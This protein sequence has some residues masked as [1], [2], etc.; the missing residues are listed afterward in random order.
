[1]KKHILYLFLTIC[2]ATLIIAQE[3]DFINE[4]ITSY[5]KDIPI[6]LDTIFL[7]KNFIAL[8]KNHMKIEYLNKNSF[9][10]WWNDLRKN[11]PPIELFLKNFSLDHLKLEILKSQNDSL[12]NFKALN[13]YFHSSN[14][15]FIKTHP[16]NTYLSIS[17]PLFNP[18]KDWCII[19]KSSY[20]PFFNAGGGGML[21]IFV[22]VDDKWILYYRF[23]LWL[24]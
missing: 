3:Y 19:V 15:E 6:P 20:N 11:K 16:K 8:G 12:I 18:N 9:E 21:Y 5:E 23:S 7:N 13:S 10:F 22:K 1:M 17:K 14:Q 4:V 24:G 2:P